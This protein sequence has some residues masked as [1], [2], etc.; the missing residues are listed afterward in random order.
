MGELEIRKYLSESLI[1]I[2]PGIV[3]GIILQII[4]KLLDISIFTAVIQIVCGGIIYI[5]LS[6]ILMYLRKDEVI[7]E[8]IKTIRMKLESK[9]VIN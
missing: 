9:K 2:F 5:T 4:Y 8:L 3:M 7:L 1:F 6:V